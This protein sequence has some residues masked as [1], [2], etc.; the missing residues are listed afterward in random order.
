MTRTAS[1]RRLGVGWVSLRSTH[2]NSFN[3]LK[4]DE[5]KYRLK[6]KIRKE[7]Y[8]DK[9]RRLIMNRLKERTL[10]KESSFDF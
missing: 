9:G 1:K 3:G 6:R 2:H 10:E 8:T 7:L 5:K 4:N